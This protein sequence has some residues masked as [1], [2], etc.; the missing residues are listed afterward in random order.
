[1]WEAPDVFLF[2]STLGFFLRNENNK[3]WVPR[4]RETP[5]VNFMCLVIRGIK[6]HRASLLECSLI[7]PVDPWNC[8]GFWII[9]WSPLLE[10]TSWFFKSTKTHSLLF[11]LSFFQRET[12]CGSI[13]SKQGV[14]ILCRLPFINNYFEYYYFGKKK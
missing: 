1:M 7:L 4:G 11:F 5:V 8:P 2:Q 13:S 12:N 14:F 6:V 9:N 10:I 3:L